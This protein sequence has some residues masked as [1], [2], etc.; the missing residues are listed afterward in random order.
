MA[1]VGVHVDHG[2][3][4]M[5][6]RI[7]HRRDDGRPQSEFSL[8]VQPVHPGVGGGQLGHDLARAVGRIVIHHQNIGRR[9][10]LVDLGDQF[11]D[12]ARLVVRGDGDQNSRGQSCLHQGGL[13]PYA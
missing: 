12:V 1:E 10:M 8:A 11:P 5:L 2:F 3:V 13:R 4:I 9:D 7:A 6:D